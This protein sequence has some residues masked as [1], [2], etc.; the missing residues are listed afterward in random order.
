MTDTMASVRTID[1]ARYVL[2]NVAPRRLSNFSQNDPRAAAVLM[3]MDIEGTEH[4]VLPH[5]IIT[6]ALCKIDTI[7]YETHGRGTLN[8][9]IAGDKKVD[10]QSFR[11]FFE[12][13]ARSYDSEICP[14]TFA[15]I[16]NEKYGTS[17][18]PLPGVA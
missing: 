2:E 1:L 5:M 16:D 10:D 7:F 17:D 9:S 14:T 12:V 4:R 13:F 3:K 15:S 6:G 11:E 18:F 8:L